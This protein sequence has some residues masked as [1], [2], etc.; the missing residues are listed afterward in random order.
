M[1]LEDWSEH[2]KNR[3]IECL[4]C[5]YLSSCTIIDIIE[6]EPKEDSDGNCIRRRKFVSRETHVPL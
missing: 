3:L 4:T 1:G 2:D 5:P 6:G